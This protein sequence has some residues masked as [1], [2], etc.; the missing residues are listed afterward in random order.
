M[1][2]TPLYLTSGYRICVA[3]PHIS[4]PADLYRATFASLAPDYG[5]GSPQIS[6]TGD[7]INVT[8][9]QRTVVM[10]P[11]ALDWRFW[12]RGYGRKVFSET[13]RN[14]TFYFD[15]CGTIERALS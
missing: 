9:P 1:I 10:Q 7:G 8:D 5:Q 12:Q 3:P 13:D 6:R 2:G 11:V 4:S 15:P 14:V